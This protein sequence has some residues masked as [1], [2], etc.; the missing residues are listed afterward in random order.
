MPLLNFILPPL[1]SSRLASPKADLYASLRSEITNQR[2][3]P[4][5]GDSNTLDYV[6]HSRHISVQ[7]Q[8]AL[9]T[10]TGF[11]LHFAGLEESRFS[12]GI[13]DLE[14]FRARGQD[15]VGKGAACPNLRSP[16]GESRGIPPPSISGARAGGKGKGSSQSTLASSLPLASCG[17]WR[18]HG[19]NLGPISCRTRAPS[20]HLQWQMC[21]NFYPKI[22]DL[23]LF[24]ARGH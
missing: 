22:I 21:R 19:I 13:I 14:L 11:L 12:A 1:S 16:L 9:G 7:D 15:F 3:S 5:V 18:S 20:L 10:P 4:L 8:V 23:E 17:L 2:G 24:P 6:L